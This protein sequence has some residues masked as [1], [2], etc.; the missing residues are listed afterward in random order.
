M[1]EELP[2]WH[3]FLKIEKELSYERWIEKYKLFL[4][5]ITELGTL[6]A[7]GAAILPKRTE[8]E[9]RQFCK[10]LYLQEQRHE[11]R[12]DELLTEA[13]QIE[14]KKWLNLKD[15]IAKDATDS[16][17]NVNDSKPPQ[18]NNEN[19]DNTPVTS[20]GKP[21]NPDDKNTEE[22][23]KDLSQPKTMY[24]K[25]ANEAF[26]IDQGKGTQTEYI[27][28]RFLESDEYFPL[29]RREMIKSW[30]YLRMKKK[31]GFLEQID[32]IGTI[33]Q[34]ASEGI[35]TQPAYKKGYLNREDMVVIFADTRGSMTP[36]ESLT[37]R[38]VSTARGDGGHPKAP[39]Y[40]FQNIP[41]GYVFE[42]RN[43][44]QPKKIAEALTKS[45]PMFTYA[46]IIS[47]AGAARGT[48]EP[49][50]VAQRT[51]MTRK[52]IKELRK[53]TAKIIWLNPMPSHRWKDTAASRIVDPNFNK[54]SEEGPLATPDVMLSVLDENN[55][56][57]QTALHLLR[58]A[59]K[60]IKT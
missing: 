25:F 23:V 33:K 12:F 32:I 5:G 8:D 15:K 20:N 50:R 45:N 11:G 39:V 49:E 59:G 54:S 34:I 14:Q 36:F 4:A 43:L 27:G 47:D 30:Q 53:Y 51:E 3:F 22:E 29:T 16:S 44:S 40:Y 46:I 2:F 48:I 10:F 13:I 37:D 19:K 28:S 58:L 57:F 60:K 42:Q 7:L 24:F 55:F 17:I 21:P 35:L 1:N 38:L 52:F 18:T 6:P 9:F 41:T 31:S 26:G 56:H